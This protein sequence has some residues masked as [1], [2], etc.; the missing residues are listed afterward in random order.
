MLNTRLE[1]FDATY[2]KSGRLPAGKVPK[3]HIMGLFVICLYDINSQVL[4]QGS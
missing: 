1:E 3:V 4:D 2:S